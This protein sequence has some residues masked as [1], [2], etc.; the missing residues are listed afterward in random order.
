MMRLVYDCRVINRTGV[1]AANAEDAAELAQTGY[2]A[3]GKWHHAECE[4]LHLQCSLRGLFLL[5]YA[6]V[7]A[8]ITAGLWLVLKYADQIDGVKPW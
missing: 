2:D 8:V 1:D 6:L 5:C 3:A 4:R 7:I